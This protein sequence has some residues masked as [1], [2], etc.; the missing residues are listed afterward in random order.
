MAALATEDAF[1]EPGTQVGYY[2]FNIG[3]LGGEI[4]RRID[5]RM[6]DRFFREEIVTPLGLDFWFGLSGDEEFRVA[7]MSRSW[8][9]RSN[10]QCTRPGIDHSVRS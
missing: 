3:W 9:I 2:F 1:W 5:G 7:P 6:F 8:T 10:W 4:V